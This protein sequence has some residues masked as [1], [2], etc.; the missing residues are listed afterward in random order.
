MAWNSV[1]MRVHYMRIGG[2]GFRA[3]RRVCIVRMVAAPVWRIDGCALQIKKLHAS[4]RER[5]AFLK[6]MGKHPCGAAC[7]LWEEY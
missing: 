4:A 7:A 6:R 2:C 1:Y 3:Y 5:V